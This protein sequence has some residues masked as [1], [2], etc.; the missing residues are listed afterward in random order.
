MTSCH[1]YGLT[2]TPWG[3]RHRYITEYVNKEDAEKMLKCLNSVKIL[4]NTYKIIEW[5]E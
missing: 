3:E 1:I 4:F 2:P 5:K